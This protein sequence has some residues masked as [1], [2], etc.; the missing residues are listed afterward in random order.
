MFQVVTGGSGSGKSAFAED[1]IC[2]YHK[3]CQAKGQ[4]SHLIYIATMIPYGEETGRKIQ[5]H[6]EMRKDKGFATIECYTNLEAVV[7][8][9]EE[10]AVKETNNACVL[11]ECM[12]NLVA[13]ELYEDTGAKEQTVECVL[14][15]IEALKNRCKTL[16]V[17]TN[18]I[19]SDAYPCSEEMQM[20]KQILSKINCK[21]AE[22][23]D[24]VTEVVYGIPVPLKTNRD[25]HGNEVPQMH[26]ASKK[27]APKMVIGGAYQGK[28]AFAEKK[29]GILDWIDGCTCSIEELYSCQ[30]I[31]HFETFIKRQMVSGREINQLPEMIIKYNPEIV[32]VT[33]EVGYGL[34]PMDAFDREFREQTG[35]ICT[36]LGELSSQ[37]DRVV[38]GIGTALKGE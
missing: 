11:L 24:Q 22:E 18:E 15:G 12:S 28:R 34:V 3:E 17:V 6:R 4:E 27:N 16:V 7:N 26:P 9:Q 13:N 14:K 33:S 30:G 36:R 38:C 5:R 25:P 1:L 35:R 31:V 20:Y 37:V 29:Y 21:M 19:C 23:A 32:I 8:K 2:R 10:F